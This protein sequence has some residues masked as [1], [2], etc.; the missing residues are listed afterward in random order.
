MVARRTC[1]RKVVGSI[2]RCTMQIFGVPL[3]KVS[4]DI[5]SVDSAGNEYPTIDSACIC[6][7]KGVKRWVYALVQLTLYGSQELEMALD[8]TGLSGEITVKH[9]EKLL[10][11][12]GLYK[13]QLYLFFYLYNNIY[14]WSA[15]TEI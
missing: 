9:F 8:W 4:T 5:F 7:M 6:R 13:M 15:A 12:K 10:A 2:P 11:W 14:Y 1:D 3:E